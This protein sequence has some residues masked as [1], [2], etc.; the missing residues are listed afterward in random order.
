MFKKK[1]GLKQQ[2]KKATRNISVDVFGYEKK[3]TKNVIRYLEG[4]AKQHQVSKGQIVVQ[5]VKDPTTVRVF[6][7]H[8][9]RLLKEVPVRELVVF[10][11]GKENASLLGVE[12][13]V[14]NGMM[15]Y[16]DGFANF[17]ELRD[18]KLQICIAADTKRVVVGAYH[19]QRHIK[20]IPI[21]E[22]INYFTR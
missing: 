3:I 21:K 12:T 20:D 8:K 18:K 2:L 11:A 17:H 19:Q 6:L 22:L 9:S 15:G 5:L 16:M 4:V 1:T 14:I 10:F 13:K 7:Y